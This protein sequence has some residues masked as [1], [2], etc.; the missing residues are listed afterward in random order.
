MRRT[1]LACGLGL[2]LL[3]VTA[4]A[5]RHS[6]QCGFVNLDDDAYVEHAPMI[7]Q[8]VRSAALVWIATS[9]H[10]NNWHPLT[11]FSHL[12]DCS[13]FGVTP[14]PMHWE[15]V[16]WHLLNTLLVFLVWRRFTGAL[17]RP[18]AVAALFALHPLHVESVAW[19]S[20]RKDLVC[21]CFWLLG[22]AAY[23]RWREKPTAWRYAGVAL[24]LALSLLGKPMAVTFPATLLL[25]DF[26]PLRRWPETTWTRLVWE[27]APL[28]AI[29]LAHSVVTYVVQHASGAGNYAARIPLDARLANAVVSYVR[30]LGKT[31]W[32]DALSPMY[33]HPG[34][35]TAWAWIGALVLLAG[36]SFAAWSRRRQN[37]AV[38]FGWLWFLGTLVPVIGVIQVGAQAMADRYTYVPLLGAF[39]ALVWGVGEAVERFPRWRP[40]VIGLI[41]GGL[42]L[43]VI[44]TH[45]QVRAWTN[46]ITLYERSIAAGEDNAAIRYLL[47]TALA[48]VGRPEAEVVAQYRRAIALTPDYINAH[49]QLAMIALRHQQ[50]D[51]AL[52]LLE[53][54]ARFEPRNE[55][56][57]M[58][59]GSYW[60]LRNDLARSLPYFE[61]AL[62][63]SPGSA[64]IHRELASVYAKFNRTADARRH[65][66][67]AIKY[68]GWA[69]GD[70]NALGFLVGNLGELA[71][72]RRL[73]ER[74]LWLDPRN[75]FSRRNLEAI[76][77]IERA[78]RP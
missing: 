6:G 78:P 60:S 19:I 42:A 32:P 37:G 25:L 7:N 56:L 67:L 65:Y 41:C 66:E 77:R 50:W 61:A 49:T 57:Q 55:S 29:V 53:Q 22:L 44:L 52:R 71:E 46:S 21:A 16:G 72:S 69:V 1:L 12:L 59:L 15:N 28:F 18:A 2:A 48:G 40:A 34:Y 23:H 26:W 9:I 36:L 70:Y 43:C 13:L 20:E 11:S 33:W 54:N 3:V 58:N 31:F 14:G 62:R 27:K 63:L 17:W 38:L 5:Y 51:E 24:C 75:E 39:T 74:A 35:W 76:A 10:S 64:L 68:D 4:F 30:Y 47:A 45:R 73:F 8:G